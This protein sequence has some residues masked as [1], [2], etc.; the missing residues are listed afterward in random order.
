MCCRLMN[1]PDEVL[2][3]GRKIGTDRS[4]HWPP[5]EECY[6]QGVAPWDRMVS[7]HFSRIAAFGDG[8]Q[9]KVLFD[10]EEGVLASQVDFCVGY[11]GGSDEGLAF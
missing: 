8:K 1:G 6:A 2:R 3:T 10:A 7:P 9:S 4:V 11:G 5:A